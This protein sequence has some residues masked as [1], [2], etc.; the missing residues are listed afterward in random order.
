MLEFKSPTTNSTGDEKVVEQLERNE[1]IGS[2][3][4]EDDTN[5]DVIR[6]S[7]F[8]STILYTA[9]LLAMVLGTLD[10]SRRGRSRTWQIRHLVLS[11]FFL[12]G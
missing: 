8:L 5:A 10:M 12:I 6:P 2:A 4:A 1:L 11:V 3:R 9:P 7:R